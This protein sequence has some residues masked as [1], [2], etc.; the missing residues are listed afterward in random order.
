MALRLAF[1]LLGV[2]VAGLPAWAQDSHLRQPKA[3]T[4]A[5]RVV[6]RVVR[7]ATQTFP[8]LFPMAVAPAREQSSTVRLLRGRAGAKTAKGAKEK[9]AKDTQGAKDSKGVKSTKDTDS[10][11]TIDTKDTKDA[12]DTKDTD[13]TPATSA[14]GTYATMPEAERVTIQSDLALI[15]DYEG[16]PG[17]FDEG[18]IAAVK[19]FQQR[20]HTRAT[21]VL[22]V[23]E[24]DALA[25]A[26][27][28]R[29]QRSDGS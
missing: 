18:T 1:V 23:P 8:T 14:A 9:D 17:N 11:D 13:R 3:A 4:A 21:G 20:H 16:A 29:Q 25:A 22:A 15:G 27:K 6:Y 19:A 2:L 24:R 12:K 7:S 28:G 5:P 26:A 10:K